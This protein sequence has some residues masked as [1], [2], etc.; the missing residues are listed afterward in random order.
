[1]KSVTVIS[2]K[3]GTGKTTLVGAIATLAENM[4]LVDCDVDAAD[5][6]LLLHP[7]V[8]HREFFQGGKLAQIDKQICT[9]C[10]TCYEVC[11]FDAIDE[12]TLAVNPLD[13]EGCGTC[14]VACPSQAIQLN[15]RNTGEWF[16]SETPYAPMVHAKL[17]I[18]Q[19]NSGLLV[20]VVR[21]EA[22]R[23][24]KR[25]ERDLILID[26]PP[27][28]G[29]PVIASITGTDLVVA[30]TGPTLSGIHD[31]ERILGLAQHFLVSA[32]VVINKH[33]LNPERTRD[34]ESLCATRGTPVLSRI[35]YDEIAVRALV[36]GEPVTR[37]QPTSRIAEAIGTIWQQVLGHLT[38]QTNAM[39]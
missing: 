19:G 36:H 14:V 27:G 7:S 28:I 4:V 30:V 39:P 6:H 15:S 31:L 32:V 24:A 26:G 21:Q 9:E 37:Y 33:D 8:Q 38:R 5:L 13:C 16:I 3:G 25:T 20:S 1:M 22:E 29:C 12:E 34:I 2:G 10:G 11:R 17:G 18:G 35:P 23:V